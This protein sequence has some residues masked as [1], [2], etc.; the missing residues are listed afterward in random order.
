[1]D[2]KEKTSEKSK[3]KRQPSKQILMFTGIFL[4]TLG[5]FFL[6]FFAGYLGLTYSP[7]IRKYALNLEG[8]EQVV[9]E[10]R[11]FVITESESNVVRI[12]EEAGH[13]GGGINR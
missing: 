11:E 8:Q 1:M 3:T 7:L 10:K 9:E 2:K 12:V 13:S 4:V 6:V 5:T